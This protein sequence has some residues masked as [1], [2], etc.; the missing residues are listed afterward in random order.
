MKRYLAFMLALTLCLSL[1][2]ACGKTEE[3]KQTEEPE[4]EEVD[5]FANSMQKSDPSQDDTYN[6]L[7]VGSSAFSYQ[8]EEMVGMAD[9]AGVKM[10]IYHLYYSGC[11]LKQH[12]DWWKNGENNY[13]MTRVDISGN[14]VTENVGLVYGM[15]LENW[16][17]IGLCAGGANEMRALTAED[18]VSSRK[19]YL[20]ELIGLFR[21]EFPASTLYWQQHNAY[22]IGYSDAAF[23]IVSPDQQQA[24]A[25]AYR[26]Q[27]KLVAQ[28]YDLQWI[29]R[30]DAGQIARANPVV[31]DTLCARLGING[32]LGDN[33]HEGDIGGGQYVTACTWFEVLFGQSC[34]GNTWRPPYD[35]GEEKIE[36]LQQAAH[37]AVANMNN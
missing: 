13:K 28:T 27:A 30:G 24:D 2:A 12:Y 26:N 33:A 11:R 15:S 36:A 17:A 23:S 20:D 34:I 3:T 10:V 37:E 5:M 35:L 8:M 19:L 32:N 22:Q 21:K 6:L 29:P 25:E 31:G 1:F 16:D 18:F 7:L 9:A 4:K 14:T